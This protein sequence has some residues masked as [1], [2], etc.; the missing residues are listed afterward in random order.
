MTTSPRPTPRPQITVSVHP[1]G[2]VLRHGIDLVYVPRLREVMEGNPAFEERVFTAGER[3]YCRAK[4]DPYPHFAARFAAKEAVLKALR[5]G[6]SAEGSDGRLLEIEIV[7]T[8]GA[9]RLS[10]SGLAARLVARGGADAPVLSLSH[11]G[12]Y[13]TASVV[14]SERRAAAGDPAETVS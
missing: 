8:H 2:R 14:W 5:R 4:A 11:A 10:T 3:A 1:E 12:D 9:P 13:A 7:R 6:I